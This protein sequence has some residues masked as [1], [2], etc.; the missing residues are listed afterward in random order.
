MAS[1]KSKLNGEEDIEVQGHPIVPSVVKYAFKFAPAILCEEQL[2]WRLVAA[3]A[4][5]D[6][7]GVTGF[8]P[9]QQK[10]HVAAIIDSQRWFHRYWDDATLVFE[11]AGVEVDGIREV[12]SEFNLDENNRVV[13][14]MKEKIHHVQTNQARR[15]C[16]GAR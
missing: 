14:L 11:A 10:K 2:L 15:A 4:V 7:C 1:P 5:L 8:G 16:A 13:R 12:M 3:R 9:S 6:A